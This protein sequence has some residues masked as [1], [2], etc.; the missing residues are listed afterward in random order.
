[1][2]DRRQF[3]TGTSA[4]AFFAAAHA[5]PA[6]PATR[7]ARARR[8]APKAPAF[9]GAEDP[10][11]LSLYLRTA[12]PLEELEDYYAGLLGLETERG[13]LGVLTVHAGRTTITF[14]QTAAEGPAPA[15]HFAF[16]I[17][18][19]KLFQAR[20]WQLARTPLLKRPPDAYSHSELEDVTDFWHW[21]AHS[22][23]F[24]DPAGNLLEYIARHDLKNGETGPFASKDILYA[25][26]IGFVAEDVPE[27]GKGLQAGTDLDLYYAGGDRFRAYGDPNGLLL[28][29]QAG[30]ARWSNQ[31]P[32]AVHST[33]AQ[34]RSARKGRFEAPHHPY[35]VG[36]NG[37][38]R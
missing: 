8:R 27:F 36:L 20:E 12:A 9:H 18:E 10:R 30:V 37:S 25:S 6:F 28:V 17:P 5:F 16:N 7:S 13:E 4:A 1:M 35:E 24:E 32:W 29:L 3:L 38:K 15:Y 2:I 26:E 21:N 31:R 11:I 19:N 33:A 22:V 14:R 34:I 23:F